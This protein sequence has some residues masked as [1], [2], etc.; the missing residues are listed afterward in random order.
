MPR[1]YS[2][3]PRGAR[4][5]ARRPS[6][7]PAGIPPWIW[8]ICG[9]TLGLCLAIAAYVVYR[10]VADQGAARLPAGPPPAAAGPP[11]LPPR[12]E[13]RFKFY[14]LLPNFE[15]VPRAENYEAPQEPARP[16]SYLIQAGSFKQAADAERRK[17][18]LALLGVESR[19][20][21]VTIEGQGTHFRVRIGPSGD[22][23]QVKAT[24]RHLTDNDIDSFFIR[25]QD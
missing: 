24:M 21:K 20:E 7:A 18:N 13:P 8:L 10:P 2:A 15:I 25:A 1:D 14:E 9:V 4:K 16:G 12:E 19:I 5:Q 3:K 23:K 6:T 22:F 17:A 11:Q